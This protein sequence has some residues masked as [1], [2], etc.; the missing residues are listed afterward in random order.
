MRY[1]QPDGGSARNS[2]CKLGDGLDV[3]SAGGYVVAPGSRLEDGGDYAWQ[4]DVPV[5]DAPEWLIEQ[6]SQRMRAEYAPDA[7]AGNISPSH[8]S[9]IL[10]ELD[11]GDYRQHDRW[12]DLMM[13]AHHATAGLGADEFIGWST[14]DPPYAG[15]GDLIRYR[16]DSLSV[17]PAL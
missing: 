5:A 12:L 14:S 15:D 11:P 2:V 4:S 3:R 17:D 9:L 13:A 1:L 10:A 6:A 7:K 16:W 8:L